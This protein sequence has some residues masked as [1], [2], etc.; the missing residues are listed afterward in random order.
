MTTVAAEGAAV[1]CSPPSV[2]SP[3]SG[4]RSRTSTTGSR[5]RRP[6]TCSS[7]ALRW[8]ALLGAWWLLAGTL[9]YVAAA[10]TPRARGGPRGALG[11]RCPRSGG[12]STPR[13]RPP[14]SAARCWRRP[15]PAP[16]VAGPPPTT[17]VRDGRGGDLASLPPATTAAPNPPAV[18]PTVPTVPTAPTT[19][20]VPTAPTRRPRRPRRPSRRPRPHRHRA[21]WRCRWSWRRATT[22]GRWPRAGSRQPVG[23]HRPTVADA[24]I[25]PY[26]VAV[27]ERNRAALASGDPNLIF[28]GEVVTL[29]ALS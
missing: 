6:P 7:P 17:F 20:T 3:R 21:A 5:S 4:F 9:L 18:P 24:E 25:A 27:C 29:P 26:W 13:S 8:V 23:S 16:R 19:P 15:A 28:P 2:A 10:V 14:S 11:R 12:W 22:S 1:V